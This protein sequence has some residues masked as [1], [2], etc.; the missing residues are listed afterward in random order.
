MISNE[1][2]YTSKNPWHW[3][4]WGDKGVFSMLWLI[5]GIIATWVCSEYGWGFALVNAAFFFI[6]LVILC[7]YR[8]TDYRKRVAAID[9]MSFERWKELKRDG[10]I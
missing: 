1:N 4:V 8:W 9:I 10:H 7:I 5:V 6:I 2:Y 3:L